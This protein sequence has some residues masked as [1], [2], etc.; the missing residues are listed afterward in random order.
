[1]VVVTWRRLSV[2]SSQR[3]SSGGG[4]HLS[5]ILPSLSKSSHPPRIDV[6]RYIKALSCAPHLKEVSARMRVGMP[7]S[8][9]E[10]LFT[11]LLSCPASPRRRE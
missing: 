4:R 5:L 11:A 10:T 6:S 2:A 8:S 1:M 3:W 9:F 7:D